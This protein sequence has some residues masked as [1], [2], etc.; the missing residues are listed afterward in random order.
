MEFL[1]PQFFFRKFSSAVPVPRYLR[2]RSTIKR[3]SKLFGVPYDLVDDV[4]DTFYLEHLRSLKP[5]VV[6]SIQHQIFGQELLSLPNIACINCHPAKLPKYRGVKPIFWAMLKG[7]EEIG[8]TVHTMEPKIDTGRIIS[9][10]CFPILNNSTLMDNYVMA[11]CI[12]ADVITEAL[13]KINENR[14]SS[15][16]PL[17]PSS[18]KYYKDPK[19]PDVERFKRAGLRII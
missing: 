10:K 2:S 6:V 4:N 7:D 18:S 13:A 12:S 9:Q 14:E 1:I 8:V 3:V 19:R 11:Y 17:I 5:D 15:L 16:F